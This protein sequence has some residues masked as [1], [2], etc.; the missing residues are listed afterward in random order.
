MGRDTLVL[1]RRYDQY[2]SP[3]STPDIGDVLFV[4]QV[5]GEEVITSPILSAQSVR[6]RIVTVTG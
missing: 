1:F 5:R 4:R 2:R 6:A 3:E